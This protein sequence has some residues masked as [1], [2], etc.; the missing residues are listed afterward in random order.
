MTVHL[1][2][3]HAN[4]RYPRSK[5]PPHKQTSEQSHPTALN[6]PSANIRSLAA[7]MVSHPTSDLEHR[8]IRI[9]STLP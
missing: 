2:V 1:I 5:L 8:R 7:E 4:Q 9:R 3:D 6:Q